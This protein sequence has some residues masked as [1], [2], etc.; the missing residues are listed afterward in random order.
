MLTSDIARRI[1]QA[2]FADLPAQAAS[3]AKVAIRDYVACALAGSRTEVAAKILVYARR[4]ELCGTAPVIGVKKL[5]LSPPAAAWVNGLFGHALDYDDLNQVA[6]AHTSVALAPAIFA[7][8]EKSRISGKQAILAYAVGFELIVKL[9]RFLNP[10]H[11]E[12]GWHSTLTLGALGAAAAA[13]KALGLAPEKISYALGIASAFA[14]GTRQNFGTM[15][16]PL[17][18]GNAARA[19]V[20]AGLLAA[21]GFSADLDILGAEYGLG[22]VMSPGAPVDLKPMA[23]RWA[24]PWEL[25]ASGIAI[26]KYSCCAGNHS[27]LDAMLKLVA[28][29]D[30][31]P[32]PVRRIICEV[33]TLVQGIL[34]RHRP[35]TA[36]EA[37]FSLEFAM[38]VAVADRAAGLAQY[39]DRRL[40]DPALRRLMAKVET[41]TLPKPL[42]KR[43]RGGGLKGARV[44]VELQSGQ[45]LGAET[46]E[47][48][49]H[50]GDPL[51]EAE[52]WA[53]FEECA[54]G[55]ISR[56][57]AQ[58]L[59]AALGGL[60]QIIDARKITRQFTL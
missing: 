37:K 15:V 14:A 38:A 59:F 25:A 60:D 50:A 18:A 58:A 11:Y 43:L 8:A 33:P 4:Y 32:E 48:R 7:L 23:R 5:R 40:K 13:G 54:D 52:H 55:V 53:K 9:A 57:R 6:V 49:G 21:D 10:D 42:E 16:K 39:T 30:M 46:G 26:K 24:R 35:R 47:A 36:A 17:H 51:S 44:T 56:P 27:S 19:G 45:K 2:R 3:M 34:H 28:E 41:K 29:N 12:H 20:T 1:A 31:T 22:K